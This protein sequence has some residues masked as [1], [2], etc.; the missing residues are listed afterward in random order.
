MQNIQQRNDNSLSQGSSSGGSRDKQEKDMR[1][2]LRV[3]KK[4]NWWKKNKK[5]TTTKM[6]PIQK[7]KKKKTEEEKK[8]INHV[9]WKVKKKIR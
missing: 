4:K 9:N 8:K 1:E 2:P 5:K 3:Q 7:T 6:Q